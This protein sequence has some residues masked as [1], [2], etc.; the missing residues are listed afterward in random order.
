MSLAGKKIHIYD[1]ETGEGETFVFTDNPYSRWM[2]GL[3]TACE[4][5]GLHEDE[6]RTILFYSTAVRSNRGVRIAKLVPFA[7]PGVTRLI[8]RGW[9]IKTPLTIRLIETP[10][11]NAI[12]S[13]ANSAIQF[14]E[15]AGTA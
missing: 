13:A 11:L 9:M 5:F 8:K 15:S 12:F 4:A 6:V 1:E 10:E 14:G 7:R 3:F 2:G